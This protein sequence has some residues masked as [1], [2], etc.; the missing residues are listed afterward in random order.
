MMLFLVLV[1]FLAPCL[2]FG[3]LTALLWCSALRKRTSAF[4]VVGAITCGIITTHFVFLLLCFALVALL[5][6]ASDFYR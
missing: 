6:M 1:I 2:V 3:T 5:N 4:R